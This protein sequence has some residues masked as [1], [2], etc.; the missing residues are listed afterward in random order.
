MVCVTAASAL[1]Q[2]RDLILLNST[3]ICE[4]QS[5]GY[6]NM[7]TRKTFYTTL[8]HQIPAAAGHGVPG[9]IR[10]HGWETLSLLSEVQCC[11]ATVGVG[12]QTLCS[13]LRES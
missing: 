1:A 6:N 10:P 2:V 4:S 3:K 12:S 7:M 9:V 13:F 5:K 8:C 11:R